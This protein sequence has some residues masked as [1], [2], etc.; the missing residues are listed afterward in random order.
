MRGRCALSLRLTLAAILL[1]TIGL[2]GA[3]ANDLAWSTFLGTASADEGRDI[4]HESTRRP[5]PQNS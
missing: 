2:T 4:R 3:R 5:A 1:A